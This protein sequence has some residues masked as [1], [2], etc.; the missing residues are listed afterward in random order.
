MEEKN[1]AQTISDSADIINLVIARLKTIPSNVELSVGNEGSFSI[2]ELIE[3]VRK[4]DDIGKKM[5]EVQLAYLRSLGKLP[6]Q[7][8]Q[9]A[10][11]A[12]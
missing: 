11:A 9:N 1:E 8:L 5:I 12:N 3:R 6:T 7:E 10:P 2:N 4:Q